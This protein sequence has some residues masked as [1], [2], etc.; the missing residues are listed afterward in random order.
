MYAGDW[1]VFI[2]NFVFSL[3]VHSVFGGFIDARKQSAVPQ[4]SSSTAN[5]GT[6]ITAGTTTNYVPLQNSFDD[7]ESVE[8]SEPSEDVVKVGQ[9]MKIIC[10]L[11]EYCKNEWIWHLSGFFWLFT[12]SLSE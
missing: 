7:E 12:Y 3:I 8:S 1:L 9:T 5:G 10:R 4:A 6:S 2:H 11:L